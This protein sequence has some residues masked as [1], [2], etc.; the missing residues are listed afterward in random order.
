MQFRRKAPKFTKLIIDFL[1]DYP[2]AK[3]EMDASFS[4]SFI[5]VLQYTFLVDFDH[6]H[7]LATQKSITGLV[8][9]IGS[10]PNI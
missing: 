3:E 5:T 2:D 7:D 10:N 6:A 9:Y 1:K 4:T 8:G